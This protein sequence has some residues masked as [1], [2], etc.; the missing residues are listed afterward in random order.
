MRFRHVAMVVVVVSA[1]CVA[2]GDEA[3]TDD[4]TKTL[5]VAVVS[6][7]SEFCDVEANLK[8][9][10]SLTKEAKG[11]GARLVCFPELALMAYSTEREILDCGVPKP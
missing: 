5:T 2:Q 6:S 4:E 1:V 8:H 7:H 9:F 11:R 3:S 10:E